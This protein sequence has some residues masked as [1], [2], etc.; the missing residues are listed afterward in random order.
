MIR[1]REVRGSW[2]AGP[3]IVA[4]G[5]TPFNTDG[6]Q[7]FV[8]GDRIWL[9]CASTSGSVSFN[10]YFKIVSRSNTVL[11]LDRSIPTISS[12]WASDTTCTAKKIVNTVC[13]V[14]ETV[15]GTSENAECS[16]RG[17]CDTQTGL[18][19]CFAGYTGED[20]SVQ[21]VLV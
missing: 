8:A 17:N 6:F 21:T 15:K 19:G 20:C 1:R 18:C 7:N 10:G 12:A 9:S 2:G 11:A 5:G 4:D 13:E 3:H 16:N 14:E